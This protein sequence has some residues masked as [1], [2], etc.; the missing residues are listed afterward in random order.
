MK[1]GM[2]DRLGR[3]AVELIV[4]LPMCGFGVLGQAV[5]VDPLSPCGLDFYSQGGV[6]LDGVAYF[7][8]NDYSR[9]AGVKRTADFPCVVAFDMKTFKRV[10]SYDF[11]FTYDSSPFLFERRDGTWL[12]V[13]HEY[14]NARTV[15]RERDTGRLAWESAPN[16]PGNY[17]FGY[18]YFRRN[19]GSALLLAPSRNGLHA[20]SGEDGKDVWYVATGNTGAVTPCVDQERGIVYYQC[21]GKVMKLRAETGEVLA[22][23]NVPA[24]NVCISWNTVLVKDGHGYFLATRWYGKPEW[25][26][27]IR[28]YDESLNLVWEQTGLPN[29]KKDTLTYTDGKLVCGSGNGWSKNYTG[30]KWKVI[31]A[32]SIRDG[33][34]VWRCDLSA[35]DY[36]AISNLPYFNGFLY[37]EGSGSAPLTSKCFRIEA[38]T[39]RLLEVLDYGRPLTS[40]ATAILAHGKLLSGDLWQDAT[41]VTQLAKNSTAEWRGPFGDPQS[42]Q[43]C[44][45]PE[46]AGARR[47]PMREIVPPEREPIPLVSEPAPGSAPPVPIPVPTGRNLVLGATVT[48][49]RQLEAG[50]YSLTN[51][52]DGRVTVNQPVTQCESCW[53]GTGASLRADPLDIVVDFGA[54]K[55]IYRVV[56]T[57]CRLKRQ[58]RLTSFDVYG[59]AG[60]DWDGNRPLARVRNSSSRL[61][62][63]TF[64]AVTT[65]K[66]CIRLLD[67]GRVDHAFP[68]ISEL[69]VYA[70]LGTAKRVLE[71]GGVFKRLSALVTPAELQA[72]ADRLRVLSNPSETESRRLETV[73]SK[74]EFHA[75]ER[76]WRTKLDTIE[77]ESRRLAARGVPEWAVAQREALA[78]YTAWIHWWIGRQQPDGQFGGAWNDDVELV[79]GWPLACFAADDAKTLTALRLLADGVWNW[80][81]VK[82]YGYSTYTDVEHSAEE[83][84]YSQPRMVLLEP[85]EPK[86]VRRCIRTAASCREHFMGI[87]AK[88]FLQFKSDWFGFKGDTPTLDPERSFDIPQYAKALKPAL[89]AA[90]AGN[91]EMKD[92]VLAYGDTWLDAA[93]AVSQ[94]RPPGLLPQRLTFPEGVPE[95][96]CRWMPVMRATHY[97]LLGC[98]LLSGD[99]KY[100]EPIEA[101]LRYMLV[102]NNAGGLPLLGRSRNREHLATADSLACLAALWRSVTG[103]ARFDEHFAQWSRRLA[104]A[105]GGRC[106]SYSYVDRTSPGL[107]I[108]EPLTVGAYR[109]ARRTCGA[110]LYVGWLTTGDKGL[111]V[112]ACRNLSYNLTDLWGPLTW[113][114]YDKT[115]RRVTSNDHLAHSIQPGAEMLMLMYTGG[116]GTIEAKYPYTPV[117][118]EG[119]SA[120]FAALVLESGPRSIRLLVCNLEPEERRVNMVLRE[121][122]PGSYQLSH[123]ADRDDDDHPDRPPPRKTLTLARGTRVPLRLPPS[124]VY[125]VEIQEAER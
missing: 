50:S 108:K 84:S 37:G 22:E 13:A 5:R 104:S 44:A 103:D 16:Q 48:A 20:L 88:G 96:V 125:V 29:G 74:L 91:S 33:S 38:A 60:T 12:I 14:K 73:E 100:L 117:T 122:L 80:G 76:V 75:E 45:G 97:H 93:G 23:T 1:M 39:G 35:Y 92:L 64:E 18:S 26:S 6:V 59:W 115:E 62:D 40:C 105:M 10:R 111:L 19:D 61:M 56:V 106:A 67:N 89:Y 82:K 31:T 9:R 2:E 94:E 15:A 68:H 21:S 120:N 65:P 85:D 112:E 79:C 114:F 123:G 4:T 53:A 116:A 49:S 101:T 98:Y 25:D 11:T 86:W 77:E 87:N 69:G 7:T 24:P 34:E 110:Q 52:T 90:W 81:P 72:E 113:W 8:A 107:W 58:Q 54:P 118:W 124:V 102:E 55:T 71:P 109:M 51:L 99:R 3:L 46:A 17:F 47:V 36:T 119:T 78:K 70:A 30:S 63:C 27:A 43:M 121:L 83:I 57:T 42:H 32:Y 95:G 66:L 41:V 28:V